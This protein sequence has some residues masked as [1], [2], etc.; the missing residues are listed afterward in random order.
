MNPGKLDRRI[1]FG[2]FLREAVFNKKVGL[3]KQLIGLA[4]K[5]IILLKIRNNQK[6]GVSK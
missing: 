5:Y 1:T 6:N 4:Q 2:D 3:Y